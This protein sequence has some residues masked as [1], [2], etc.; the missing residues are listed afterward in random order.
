MN[1]TGS[2]SCV[3]TVYSLISPGQWSVCVSRRSVSV[4][5]MCEAQQYRLAVSVVVWCVLCPPPCPLP[6]HCPCWDVTGSVSL[7]PAWR[8]DVPTVTHMHPQWHRDVL[9]HTDVLTVTPWCTHSHTN[10]LTVILRC[11]HSYTGDVLT[12][13][14]CVSSVRS[15]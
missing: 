3:Y 11:T 10:V 7:S 5:R 15:M 2:Y 1:T 13:L 9:S 4:F 14:R 12:V 6:S 8:W